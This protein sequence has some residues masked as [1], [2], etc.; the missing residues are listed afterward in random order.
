MI[1]L[2]TPR[3]VEAAVFNCPSGN[4]TCLIDAINTANA[5]GEANT[6][7]LEAGTYTLTVVDNTTDAPNGLPLVTSILTIMGLGAET[8]IIERDVSAAPF[9]ILQNAGALTLEAVAI[10][11]GLTVGSGPGGGL[12]T[13]GGT[14]T[15][16]DSL[17][18]GNTAS[19]GG[20]I[21]S[22]EGS[23][24]IIN[25]VIS[26]NT[27]R[28]IGGGI[29][30]PYR[31]GVAVNITNSTISGN[32][33]IDGGGG[34]ISLS[35]PIT[36]ITNSTIS[37]N[38]AIVG[39]GILVMGG[40]RVNIT[41]STISGNTARDPSGTFA[42]DGGG[43]HNAYEAEV[44]ITN[45]T[46]SG[47]SAGRAGGG[48]ANNC[49]VPHLCGPVSLNN[50]ILAR[51]TAQEAGPEC[52][53]PV[54]SLGNNLIDDPTRCTITLLPTDLTRDPELGDFTDDGTPGHGHFPLLATS[55]A[56]NAG[57]DGVCPPTDQLGQPRVGICDIGAIE[58]QP[59]PVLLVAVDIKPGS[60]PN[61]INP[62]SK[63]V[64]PVAILTTDTFDATTVDPLSVK[65]G[66][67]GATEAH[68]RGHRQDV[69]RDGKKD[70]VLHFRTQDTGIV[71][72]DTSASLTGKTFSGQAIKGSDWIRTVGCK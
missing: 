22:H 29:Y 61:S 59:E 23:V 50:S 41:N 35:A 58:F 21:S 9:R 7:I 38:T 30:I 3:L 14:M 42:E 16:A 60:F 15:I 19:E 49:E 17:I 62:R 33:A 32:T 72:G 25:S 27:A 55:P 63:G 65:F 47:N 2:A 43:I 56:I 39:G 8:T 24:T 10:R 67:D 44:S 34:G 71:C 68:G 46:I 37:G 53:G 1:L 40:G 54:T 48:I 4:V 70:L 64:I 45:S 51:N 69:N 57:N 6:I 18:V 5:N 28:N 13:G 52:F 66:P 26:E 11:G 31:F 20:G 36:N 12:Y